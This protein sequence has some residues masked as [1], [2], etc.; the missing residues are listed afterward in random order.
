MLIL[1][2]NPNSYSYLKD[3]TNDSYNSYHNLEA[4]W[5]LIEDL[6]WPWIRFWKWLQHN[7]TIHSNKKCFFGIVNFQNCKT[8]KSLIKKINFGKTKK[9]RD[10]DVVPTSYLCESLYPLVNLCEPMVNSWPSLVENCIKHML[11]LFVQ[12][13]HN[14]F[15]SLF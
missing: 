6:M 2:R 15:D 8:P 13:M 12:F 14:P 9:K 1:Q 4:N 10:F 5:C 7:R 3:K 11:W